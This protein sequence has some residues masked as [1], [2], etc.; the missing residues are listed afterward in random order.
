MGQPLSLDCVSGFLRRLMRGRVAVL[1]RLALGSR[2]RRQS[3]GRNSGARPAA[4]LQRP[5][6][7]QAITPRRGAAG[8]HPRALACARGLSLEELRAG[9]AE[10]DLTCRSL[11]LILQSVSL[12]YGRSRGR[13]R[14]G[15]GCAAPGPGFSK[16]DY[17]VYTPRSGASSAG[18]DPASINPTVPMPSACAHSCFLM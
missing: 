18:A 11:D 16:G 4:L 7:R 9:L 8:C 5:G 13:A 3:A 17:V 2:P 6:W 1:R 15:R 14:S 10:S 12:G